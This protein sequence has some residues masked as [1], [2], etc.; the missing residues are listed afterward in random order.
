MKDNNLI[1]ERKYKGDKENENDIVSFPASNTFDFIDKTLIHAHPDKETFPKFKC[2]YLTFR[3]EGG[4]MDNIYHIERMVSIN[5][6]K[7]DAI[8]EEFTDLEFVRIREYI[9]ERSGCKMNF[10]ECDKYIFYFLK[11]VAIIKENFSKAEGSSKHIYLTWDE[12]PFER[13][14]NQEIQEIENIGLKGKEKEAIVKIRVNQSTFRNELLKKYSHCV[15]CKVHNAEL[16]IASHIKPWSESDEFEKLDVNNGFIMCPNHDGLFD[17]GYISFDSNGKIII[18]DKL[19][20][21][22]C[23]FLNINK[24]MSIDISLRNQV[25]L[26]Y[27]RKNKFI[28]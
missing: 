20:D 15:L 28:K 22:D 17:K 27:H 5:P 10:G 12:I 14:E 7:I 19:D 1:N 21:I 3:K 13:F 18:S 16:L 24:D 4:Y 9:D 23:I 6:H 11:K 8:R 2:K 26:E 25:Y